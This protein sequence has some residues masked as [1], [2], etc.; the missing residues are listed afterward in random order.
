MANILLMKPV[1]KA[2]P[3]LVALVEEGRSIVKKQAGK[4]V[5]EQPP[6][7]PLLTSKNVRSGPC[8]MATFIATHVRAFYQVDAAIIP[9]GKVRGNKDYPDGKLSFVD[10]LGELPFN[11]NQVVLVSMTGLQLQDA[12]SFSHQYYR[13]RGGYIHT[14][15]GTKY[16]GTKGR[17][18]KLAGKAVTAED[19][20]EA[21]KWV[22]DEAAASARRKSMSLPALPAESVTSSTSAAPEDATA[23][24]AAATT[25]ATTTI[26]VDGVDGA[27]VDL[28]CE[29]DVCR[30]RPFLVRPL[31]I[32][33]PLT[34]LNGMDNIPAIREAGIRNTVSVAQVDDL[35]L[36]QHVVMRSLSSDREKKH[37]IA[38]ERLSASPALSPRA[39]AMNPKLVSYHHMH[40]IHPRTNPQAAVIDDVDSSNTTSTSTSSASASSSSSAAAA[41]TNTSFLQRGPLSPPTPADFEL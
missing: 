1:L 17:L 37:A 11:D 25:A 36:L 26:V 2:A 31:W 32:A 16:D 9:A 41:V 21:R 3:E 18:V 8:T 22:E 5:Y 10:V 34:H 4:V 20:A 23:A 30:Q 40:H 19:V 33:C 15:A 6:S 35:L 24:A 12:L 29:T 39:L 14:D 27:G 13:G 7:L 28:N 38:A